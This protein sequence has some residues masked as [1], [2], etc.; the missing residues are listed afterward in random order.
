MTQSDRRTKR[1]IPV[2]ISIREVAERAKVSHATVSRVLNNVDVPI[3]PETRQLV[4]HIAAE[5]GYQP[6]RAARALATGRSQTIALWATNLRS[7]YYGDVIHHTHEEITRHDY[8]MLVSSLRLLDNA[9]FDT[10]KLLSWQVDGILAID[11]PRGTIPGLEGSLLNGKPFVNIGAYIVPDTDFVQ[12]DFRN[13][14]AEAV[15]HLASV[16]CKRIA[17]LVPD[18]FDWYEE[19]H[20]PRLEGYREAIAELGREPEYIVTRDEKRESTAPALRGYI[21]K[22]GCPD[23]LFCYNDDMAIGAYPTLRAFGLR[24]PEDVAIVGC[25][26]I[27]DTSYLYPPLTTIVQPLDQM[28]ATAWSFL[29]Q[30]I[31]DP[32]MPL[33]QLVLEPRLEIRGSSQK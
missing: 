5:L 32:S 28:C 22:Q 15:R 9:T 14:S 27:R 30:R 17:Y 33:Q 16:G 31:D 20:D 7:A 21:E 2:K 23:G 6:N 1:Q 8:E 18:W 29:K 4:R 12:V 25:D 24:I 19:S 3:A 11:L 26:G 10:S 13:Q